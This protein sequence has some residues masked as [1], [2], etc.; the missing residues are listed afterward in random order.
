[1]PTQNFPSA[2]EPAPVAALV[3]PVEEIGFSVRNEKGRQTGGLQANEI[4]CLLRYAIHDVGTEF[5]VLVANFAGF[6]V[7]GSIAPCLRFFE[8]VKNVNGNSRT[9]RGTFKRHHLLACGNG[10]AARVP[11]ARPRRKV[12]VGATGKR[13]RTLRIDLEYDRA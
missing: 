13:Q 6:F 11:D 7:F 12:T 5:R 1:M 4:G 10:F 3:L 9:W 8:A 2:R